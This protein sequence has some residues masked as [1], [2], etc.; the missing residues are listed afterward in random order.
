M[1]GGSFVPSYMSMPGEG[2][3]LPIALSAREAM[4]TCRGNESS[5]HQCPNVLLVRSVCRDT[6]R[7]PMCLFVR[8]ELKLMHLAVLTI[9]ISQSVVMTLSFLCSGRV[10]LLALSTHVLCLLRVL[11]LQTLRESP[12]QSWSPILGRFVPFSQIADGLHRPR[13]LTT[14]RLD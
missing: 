10:N 11:R 4:P 5:F 6:S 14:S 2:Y 3:D 13:D 7:P 12:M 9:K 8:R 1:R